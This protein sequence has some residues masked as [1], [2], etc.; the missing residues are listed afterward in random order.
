[1]SLAAKLEKL[2]AQ[3]Q[4]IE[5]LLTKERDAENSAATLVFA[6]L[7]SASQT[8]FRIAQDPNHVGGLSKKEQKLFTEWLSRNAPAPTQPTQTTQP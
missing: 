6:K 3:Q 2:K 1:M 8:A 7:I 5:E 4:N